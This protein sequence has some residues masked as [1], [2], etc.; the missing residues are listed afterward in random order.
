MTLRPPYPIQPQIRPQGPA[1]PT[2]GP[3][4]QGQGQLQ[5]KGPFPHACHSPPS[6]PPP[7]VQQEET[8]GHQGRAWSPPPIPPPKA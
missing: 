4:H 8:L 7:Q 2:Q 6:I 3:I 1:P 5:I